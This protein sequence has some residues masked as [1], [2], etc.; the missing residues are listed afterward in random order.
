MSITRYLC[1]LACGWHH[2]QPDPDLSDPGAVH[3]FIAQDWATGIDALV[4]GFAA[5]EAAVV[6][7]AL[8]AH[9]GTHTLVEWVTALVEAQRK[10]QPV[11]EEYGHP[12]S[13]GGVHTW[14]LD[15]EVLEI[16]PLAKRIEH[17][18]RHGTV[19]RCRIVELDDWE[20]IT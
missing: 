9:L 14:N 5:G 4:A 17:T 13:G 19:L 10:M 8:K 18:Q 7:E 6:E 16:Y 3:P 20:E 1:P 11:V 2:D 15:P 12:M